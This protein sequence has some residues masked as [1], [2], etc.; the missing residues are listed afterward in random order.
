MPLDR[1]IEEGDDYERA[2]HEQQLERCC[3]ELQGEAAPL[4]ALEQPATDA[5]SADTRGL[6]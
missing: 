4:T 1:I 6:R 3:T 5:D 2:D